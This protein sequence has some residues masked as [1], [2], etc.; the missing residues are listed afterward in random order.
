MNFI[1]KLINKTYRRQIKHVA[2]LITVNI[3]LQGKYLPLPEFNLQD[4][5]FVEHM[6]TLKLQRHKPQ[7]LRQIMH[8]LFFKN[9]V[10]LSRNYM[11]PDFLGSAGE[12]RRKLFLHLSGFLFINL[13][14]SLRDRNIDA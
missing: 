12:P 14:F 1:R 7:M 11:L 13:L 3:F 8:G 9:V 10:K 6:V 5:H 4:R 2:D